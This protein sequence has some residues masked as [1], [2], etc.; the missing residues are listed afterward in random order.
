M[1]FAWL[2]SARHKRF[3]LGWPT[4]YMPLGLAMLAAVLEKTGADVRIID[5]LAYDIVER[6]AEKTTFGLPL[7]ALGEVI[8]GFS[9][10]VVGISNLVSAFIEDALA[11]ARLVK[12]TDPTIQVVMGG[13][14][15]SL[16]TQNLDLLA[17]NP[18]I[19]VLVRG[20]GEATLSELIAHYDPSRQKFESLDVVA[21]LVIRSASGEVTLTPPR[22]FVRNLDELPWPAY[23]LLDLDRM[24]TNPY[25]ARY[26]AP[27]DGG[28][29][30]PMHASRGCP[31]S[32]CFCS[33]HTQVGRAHRAH[34]LAYVQAHLQ[35]VKRSYG[36]SHV[37][38]EDDNFT[39][40]PTRALALLRAIEGLEITWHTPNGL[41]ADTITESLAERISASGATSVTIAVESGDQH[42]LDSVIRKRRTGRPANAES[43]EHSVIGG[44]EHCA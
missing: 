19:D 11:V 34:S 4:T 35:H 16:E 41:R 20:E 1:A 29:T 27:K 42:T 15:P 30:L 5:C 25:Y 9:P 31:Y 38:F 43:G 14:E 17:N 39:L 28:C 33:V 44:R 7:Y 40:N 2:S 21:G 8:N 23:H 18:A 36:I 6:S 26:R 32:C 12:G 10:H 3:P 24:F 22:T 13:I 37:S